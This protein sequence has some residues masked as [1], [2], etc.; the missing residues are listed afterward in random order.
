MFGLTIFNDFC[1]NCNNFYEQKRNSSIKFKID[2]SENQF[3][4]LLPSSNSSILLLF[5]LTKKTHTLYDR[6]ELNFPLFE[7]RNETFEVIAYC[8]SP[9]SIKLIATIEHFAININ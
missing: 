1:C 4:T 2:F 5:R 8:S 3:R 9:K 7:V 6:S